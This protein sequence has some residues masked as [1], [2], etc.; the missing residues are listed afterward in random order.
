[1]KASFCAKTGP[2][3]HADEQ[4]LLFSDVLAWDEIELS[5]VPRNSMLELAPWQD[6]DKESTGKCWVAAAGGNLLCC[7]II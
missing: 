4:L 3:P 1:M 7:D 2:D 5:G 6:R